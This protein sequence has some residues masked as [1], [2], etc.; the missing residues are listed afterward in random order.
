MIKS[1]ELLNSKLTNVLTL[2]DSKWNYANSILY[3]MCSKNP[4]HIDADIIVGKIWLIGRSYA[5]AIERRK[6]KDENDDDDFYYEVVAP[7]MLSIGETLDERIAELNNYTVL[8]EE[9]LDLVLNT[10]KMLTD[11]FF[12]I[13]ELEKRSLAS[14]YLHFHC[15]QMFFIYDRSLPICSCRYLPFIAV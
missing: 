12:D 2:E 1:S 7:K 11:A 6:N 15:P 5:A 9:K 3:E 10:H 4:L 13:T 14:K 8:T